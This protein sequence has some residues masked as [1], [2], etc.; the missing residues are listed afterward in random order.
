[1]KEQ[2]MYRKLAKYY[3]KIYHW[4][5]Y[6]KEVDDINKIIIEFKKS[7]G[8]SLLD[9]G[10]GTGSHI[11]FFKNDFKCTGLDLNEDILEIA[12]KKLP[13]T[14]FVQSDM[15]EMNLGKKFDIIVCLFSSIGYL[16][17]EEKLLKAIKKFSEH[18]YPGGIVLIEPWLTSDI[19]K[20][21][22]VHMT[23]YDGEDMKIAR[24]NTSQLKDGI[25]SY[26][27]MHYL[28]GEPK[29][30]VV[31]IVDKH[32]LAMFSHEL[33]MDFMKQSG[34]ITTKLTDDLNTTRGLL[35]GVKE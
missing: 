11:Q 3:D 17:T 21:G 7:K 1:M 35:I 32:E 20:E 26:F 2:A 29:K 25:I 16:L 31:H 5:D 15:A 9:V 28:I 13:K 12:R 10:C 33:I 30:P 6:K 8:N 24:V 4:K 22:S 19:F 18:L 23:V 27:E 34:L 14:D